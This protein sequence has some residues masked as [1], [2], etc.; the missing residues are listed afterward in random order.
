MW[1][2]SI[3]PMH[4]TC[5]LILAAVMHAF[6]NGTDAKVQFM[7]IVLQKQSRQRPSLQ[8]TC[9]M[10]YI[11]S[12]D[13][14]VLLHSGCFEHCIRRIRSMPQDIST[15]RRQV[16]HSFCVFVCRLR[17]RDYSVYLYLC[18]CLVC[19]EASPTLGVRV[20]GLFLEERQ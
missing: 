18:S 14:V 3:G 16:L 20:R 13:Y 9:H 17:I 10:W 19:D 12:P 2:R 7:R 5:L 15:D 11:Q 4:E 6:E 1:R 8:V